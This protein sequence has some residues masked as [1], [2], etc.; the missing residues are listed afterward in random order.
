MPDCQ[1]GLPAFPGFAITPRMTIVAA[2]RY[3][4][5]QPLPE[6]IAVNGQPRTDLPAGQFDWVGLCDPTADEMDRVRRQFGLHRLA[7]EDALTPAQPPKV[8]TY[9]KLTFIIARTAEYASDVDDTLVYGQTAIFVGCDFVVTVR[10]GSA[11]AH[12]KLRAKLED[13]PEHLMQGPDYVA[14]ALLDFIVDGFEPI[15]DRVETTVQ[16]LEELTVAAFPEQDTIRRIFHLRRQLR[17]LG[18]V[19]G[20]MEEVSHKL[21]S[22]DLPAIDVGAR[23]WFRDVYDHTR[24]T[25]SHL[26]GLNDTLAYI[27]EA[28]S[29]L[30][31]HRQG[32][33]TRELA[34]WAA[35]LAV[36]TAIAGIYGM[37]FQFMPE[38]T[39]HYGYFLVVGAMVSVCITL[40]LRFRR[41]GWL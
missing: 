11:R 13:D 14:H 5:G 8:D 7:V 30:E 35:I 15:V 10:F 27:V 34:A 33:I 12:T 32:E 29:M 4:A 36:P 41:I 28:G 38:L 19:I 37:N 6:E 16:E 17:K 2:R 31:Q 9:E 18:Y 26:R 1:G 22:E 39:W 20:P 21:A 3:E 40:W 24:R 25:M 23:I